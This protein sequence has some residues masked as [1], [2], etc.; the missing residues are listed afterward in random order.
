MICDIYTSS[1][2][3]GAYLFLSEGAPVAGLPENV[4]NALGQLSFFK[5]VSLEEGKPLIA[6]D[7]ATIVKSINEKGFYIQGV[8]TTSSVSE[9]GAAVGGGILLASLGL[10]PVGAIFGAV[11]GYA[12]SKTAKE[13]EG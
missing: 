11:A 6:V 13:E 1:K 7:P 3:P 9:L 10:G 5:K 8:K 4:L 2:K 12:L